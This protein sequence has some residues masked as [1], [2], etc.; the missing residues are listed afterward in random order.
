MEENLKIPLSDDKF[1]YGTF[2]GPL[3]N[4]LIIFAHGFT[5]DKDEHIFFNG[6]RFF[7]KNN[8]SSF[9]FNFYGEQEDSRQLNECDI[10]NHIS[11]LETVIE[12]FK[13]KTPQI[14]VVA[15]SFGGLITLLSRK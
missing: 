11:D 2:R 10:S 15:H 1:I 14:F 6:S 8:I 5:G 12:Y 3:T 7:E 4:P 13:N 9:R